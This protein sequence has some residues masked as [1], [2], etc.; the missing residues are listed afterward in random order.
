VIADD[1]LGEDVGDLAV[2]F[3]VS[4]HV[5]LHGERDIGVTDPRAERTRHAPVRA[6]QRAL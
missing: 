1:Q 6:A 2:R 5:L 4:L 3:Q